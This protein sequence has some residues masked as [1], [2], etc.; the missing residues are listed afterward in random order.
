MKQNNCI[1]CG[2]ELTD[3]N[4]YRSRKIKNGRNCIFCH[5]IKR[6]RRKVREKAFAPHLL[7]RFLNRK[8]KAP[9]DR[10]QEGYVY[11]ISN[12]AYVGWY[13]IGMAVDAEDRVMAYQT[14]TPLRDF[15]LEYKRYF[16]DRRSA[17]RLCH[18]LIELESRGRNGEWFKIGLK[19]AKDIIECVS[20]D[21][22]AQNTDEEQY[23]QQTF[24]F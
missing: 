3:S 20:D 13:K 12:P 14:S 16:N 24:N 22:F 10:V 15:K 8:T 17:E 19:R 18:L 5:D 1:G 6:L 23:V 21:S 9:Y 7:A 11:I 4:W 2:V